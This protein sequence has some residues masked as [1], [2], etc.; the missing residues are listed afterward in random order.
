MQ[1][2]YYKQYEKQLPTYDEV[3]EELESRRAQY[4]EL[5]DWYHTLYGLQVAKEEGQVIEENL[6]LTKTFFYRPDQDY[7]GMQETVME[8]L[9]ALNAVEAELVALQFRLAKSD[10][11]EEN[12]KKI[13][14]NT[15]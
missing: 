3:V 5:S 2:V 11:K 10:V 8:A 12:K 15:W 7:A 14:L 13:G 6:E 1:F 4:V 9:D